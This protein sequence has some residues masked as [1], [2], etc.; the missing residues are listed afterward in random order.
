LDKANKTLELTVKVRLDFQEKVWFPGRKDT[1]K[2]SNNPNVD[3]ITRISNFKTRFVTNVERIWSKHPFKLVPNTTNCIPEYAKDGFQPKLKIQ[4][5]GKKE[6]TDFV[7]VVFADKLFSGATWDKFRGHA[8]IKAL[9]AQV[10]ESTPANTLAHE[11]GHLMGFAHPGFYVAELAPILMAG[12][13]GNDPE[14]YNADWYALMGGGEHMRGL[15]FAAWKHYLNNDP[16][17]KAFAPWKAKFSYLE[18]HE[19]FLRWRQSP[20]NDE[21]HIDDFTPV[22][23][24][25]GPVLP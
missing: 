17:L 19:I 5:V 13:R 4:V 12:D 6:K 20:Y 22:L 18:G 11:F 9:E 25:D 7:F 23:E 2:A 16:D 21:L 14:A 8:K 3:D 24:G 15:Y 10:A 1:W